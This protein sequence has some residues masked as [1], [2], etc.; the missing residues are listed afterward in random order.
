M[1]FCHG[2]FFGRYTEEQ[3]T[4]NKVEYWWN[5]M[6]L[7]KRY[8]SFFL[9]LFLVEGEKSIQVAYSIVKMTGVS[10][11]RWSNFQPNV[12][13]FFFFQWLM[14]KMVAYIARTN[15][16]MVQQHPLDKLSITGCVQLIKSHS[17]VYITT[18]IDQP[19]WKQRNTKAA[20][21]GNVSHMFS[22]LVHCQE[23]IERFNLKIKRQLINYLS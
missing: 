21:P 17:Q 14:V 23:Q 18:T 1:N 8:T 11:F 3:D 6:K 4:S 2:F 13:V 20:Q 9:S 10:I 5:V 15:V 7:T 16:D 19:Q 22:L 12:W